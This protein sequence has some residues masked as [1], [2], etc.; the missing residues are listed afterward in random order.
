MQLPNLM[1]PAEV[2][3]MHSL[4]MLLATRRYGKSEPEVDVSV[5]PG[6]YKISMVRM[7]Q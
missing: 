1:Q 3:R 7:R 2:G 5:R 4:Y 6:V